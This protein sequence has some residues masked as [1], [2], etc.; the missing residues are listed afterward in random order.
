MIRPNKLKF[1]LCCHRNNSVPFLFLLPSHTTNH[2]L[3]PDVGKFFPTTSN[4]WHLWKTESCSVISNSLQPHG[5]YSPWNFPGQNT[6]VG[7]LSLLQG[8]FPSQGLNPGVLHYRRI[9]YQL[10]YQGSPGKPLTNACC[11]CII[12]KEPDFLLL[13]H[14]DLFL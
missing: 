8:V 6:G 5:L 7:S 12:N 10:S 2:S 14:W 4:L 3:T 11:L 13:N 9:L 1:S